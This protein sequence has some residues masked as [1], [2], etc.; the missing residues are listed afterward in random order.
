MNETHN[1]NLNSKLIDIIK[2]EGS[3]PFTAVRKGDNWYLMM[4]KYRLSEPRQTFEEVEEDAK[5][6]SWL[7]LMQVMRI[8]IQDEKEEQALRET[9]NRQQQEL[10]F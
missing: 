1:S 3:E 8:V 4:G 7:R 2:L 9:I 5:S 6:T 10:K